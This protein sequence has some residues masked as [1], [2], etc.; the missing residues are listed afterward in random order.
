[1][2]EK[3]YKAVF[4]CP[5]YGERFVWYVSSRHKAM[6]MMHQQICDHKKRLKRYQGMT[7]GVDFHLEVKPLFKENPDVG[8]PD[9]SMYII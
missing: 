8:V 9:L 4:T 6:K 2:S 5:Q 7:H 3:V 1:M